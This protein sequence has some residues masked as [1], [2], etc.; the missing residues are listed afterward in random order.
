MRSLRF[1]SAA[2]PLAPG[3]YEPINGELWDTKSGNVIGGYRS[4]AEPLAMVHETIRRHGDQHADVL[5]LGCED[6]RGR[7]HAIAQGRERAELT[8]RADRHQAVTA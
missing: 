6:S 8:R 3:C 4:T 1:G 2:P 7:S 5:F